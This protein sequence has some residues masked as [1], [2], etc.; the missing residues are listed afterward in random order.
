MSDARENDALERILAELIDDATASDKAYMG[1]YADRLR[2][3][4]AA[5]AARVTEAE[6]RYRLAHILATSSEDDCNALDAEVMRLTNLLRERNATAFR[7][8]AEAEAV[9]QA[10]LDYTLAVEHDDALPDWPHIQNL[11]RRYFEPLPTETEETR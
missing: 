8:G 10:I 3:L 5:E 7:R 11:A 2:A 6:G 4:F 9:L 1:E